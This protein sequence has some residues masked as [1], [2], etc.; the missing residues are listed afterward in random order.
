MKMR[1]SFSK[2]TLL[3]GLLSLTACAVPTQ[4]TGASY[5]RDEVRMV[6][7]VQL[8]IIVD[9]RAVSL[10]AR[11]RALAVLSGVQWVQL[12]ARVSMTVERQKSLPC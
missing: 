12:R 1:N 4:Q 8:G 2:I 6:Q 7:E 10:R 9:A 5:S 3:V 11:K